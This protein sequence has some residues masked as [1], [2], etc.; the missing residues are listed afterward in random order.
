MPLSLPQHPLHL[1]HRR[2]SPGAAAGCQAAGVHWLED[3]RICRHRR[4]GV[5]RALLAV[6]HHLHPAHGT[7]EARPV[8]FLL[9]HRNP[10]G[11]IIPIG[12]G[13][14][15]VQD[16]DVRHAAHCSEPDHPAHGAYVSRRPDYRH[17]CQPGGDVPRLRRVQS[18]TNTGY[19]A[20]RC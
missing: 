8:P 18:G 6:R 19:Y 12:N 10:H 5:R 3:V 2:S 14:R 7:A 16:A 9:A 13:L 20:D 11:T 15:G 17:Y 1:A 4:R